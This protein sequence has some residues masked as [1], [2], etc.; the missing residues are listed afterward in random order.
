MR[1]DGED[2]GFVATRTRP[3]GACE[4][5]ALHARQIPVDKNHRE[6][7]LGETGERRRSIG[8]G[9]GGV[10]DALRDALHDDPVVFLVFDDERASGPALRANGE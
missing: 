4:V 8:R 1:G 7:A 3:E 9:C 6:P 5:A 10:A 2:D